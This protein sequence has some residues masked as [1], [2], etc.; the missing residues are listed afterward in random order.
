MSCRG[1]NNKGTIRTW[2]WHT[3][4]VPTCL[5]PGGGYSWSQPWRGGRPRR[6]LPLPPHTPPPGQHQEVPA[7]SLPGCLP[8]YFLLQML[9]V[10]WGTQ[11]GWD[12][13]GWA[14]RWSENYLVKMLRTQPVWSCKDEV[15]RLECVSVT[16]WLSISPVSGITLAWHTDR[17]H[18][19]FDQPLIWERDHHNILTSEFRKFI[20]GPCPSCLAYGSSTSVRRNGGIGM[21][22]CRV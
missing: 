3:H 6:H 5:A 13:T 22:A 20:N 17:H 7:H 16:K 21:V 18:L 15:N 11:T 10:L 1:N 8:G 9:W 19:N 12:Q 2:T 14:E 4:P